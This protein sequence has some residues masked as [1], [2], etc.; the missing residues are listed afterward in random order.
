MLLNE[1]CVLVLEK[2]PVEFPLK[3]AIIL[4]WH[5]LVKPTMFLKFSQQKTKVCQW[6]V[7]SLQEILH[8]ACVSWELIQARFY[9]F[10]CL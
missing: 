5:F 9:E 4:F 6:V 2:K 7:V 1:N 10:S 8:T 3:F